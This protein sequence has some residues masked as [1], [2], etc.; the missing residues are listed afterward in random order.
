V[1]SVIA[2]DHTLP[3]HHPAHGKTQSDGRP[4]LYICRE[5]TC[6]APVTEP[7]DIAGLLARPTH[8]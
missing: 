8:R 7:S 4:T 5:M 6:S 3:A 1:I 2:A